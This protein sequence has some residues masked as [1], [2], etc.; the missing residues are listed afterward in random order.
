MSVLSS[1]LAQTPPWSHA[2]ARAVCQSTNA[3]M[4][5]LN[6]PK[7]CLT[8]N[9]A[10]IV[11]ASCTETANFNNPTGLQ[12]SI[13]Q[14]GSFVDSI[15]N[16]QQP[17]QCD[18]VLYTPLFSHVLLA[19]IKVAKTGR[20]GNHRTKAQRQLQR[21][22]AD[23]LNLPNVQNKLSLARE[24]TCAFFHRPPSS[25]SLTGNQVRAANTF[26]RID[27]I[28]SQMDTHG[29]NLNGIPKKYSPIQSLGFE[30]WEFPNNH[31]YV[32]N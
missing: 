25:L 20:I 2:T 9:R 11:L 5:G 22:L 18:F 31:V 21:T 23:F 6:D 17:P 3:V 4:F 1:I 30:Y 15:R 19:E 12:I 27:R 10:V 13:F 28:T 29:C 16:V 7:S 26:H 32:F 24:R 14:Y 8:S